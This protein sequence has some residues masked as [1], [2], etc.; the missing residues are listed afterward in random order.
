MVD[1]GVAED[2]IKPSD[3][4]LVAAQPGGLLHGADVCSLDDV[5]GGGAGVDAPFYE[6]E[7]LPSLGEEA[8]DYVGLH[9]S[10][11]LLGEGMESDSTPS[12]LLS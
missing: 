4:G 11:A 2:A 9:G 7:E 10:A 5:F 3:G 6:L 12:T 8:F 1:D